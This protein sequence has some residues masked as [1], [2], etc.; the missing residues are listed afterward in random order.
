M[1][2]P[3]VNLGNPLRCIPLEA[4]TVASFTILPTDLFFALVSTVITFPVSKVFGYL[5][6]KLLGLISYILRATI[7]NRLTRHIVPSVSTLDD[8]IKNVF[9]T[10]GELLKTLV[11]SLINSIFLAIGLPLGIVL[12]LIV[13][14][15]FSIVSYIGLTLSICKETI[16]DLYGVL[17]NAKEELSTLTGVGAK[18]ALLIFKLPYRLVVTSLSHSL[19][20]A[21]ATLYRVL[22]L[23]FAGLIAP[24]YM[25]SSLFSLNNRFNIYC[26]ESIGGVI[27]DFIRD[28]QDERKG[29]VYNLISARFP[30]RL[31]SLATSPVETKQE[32][33]SAIPPV[34]SGPA[35]AS[36]GISKG[37]EVSA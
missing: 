24:L 33:P 3:R 29:N 10:V 20:F 30:S 34:K 25:L 11:L 13:L 19:H 26:Y 2:S 17:K 12:T 15:V 35:S 14:P 6:D 28:M 32:A 1:V 36:E 21:L 7:N 16:L 37:P 9:S 23:P 27:N 22:S 18:A 4:A 5:T 8:K 31:V